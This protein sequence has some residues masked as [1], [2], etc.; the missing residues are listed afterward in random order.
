GSDV[1]GRRHAIDEGGGEV[2]LG[3]AGY[4]S[5]ADTARHHHCPLSGRRSG[6]LWPASLGDTALLAHPHLA[7]PV[8][9]SL[10]CDGLAGD[11]SLYGPGHFRPRT[12]ISATRGQYSLH[13]PRDHHRR[14]IHRAMVRGD[15]GAR[16]G[17][18]FLVWSPGLGIRRYRPLLAVV[19][20]CRLD[21]V[22]A[23]GRSC[24]VASV[25]GRFGV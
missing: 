18:Q 4:V 19:L 15:A 5:P 16:A 10:D 3:A 20:L 17:A 6:S 23:A 13:L 9:G 2:L 7:Y 24:A 14:R 11:R 22:A 25:E 1:A 8:G 21:V 12:Q